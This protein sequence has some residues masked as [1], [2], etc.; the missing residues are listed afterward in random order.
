MMLEPANDTKCFSCL[1][2]FGEHFE[3]YD[4][5]RAGCTRRYEGQRSDGPCT[6]KGFQIPLRFRTSPARVPDPLGPSGDDQYAVLTISTKEA[7]ANGAAANSTPA[8]D[9]ATTG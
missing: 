8:P 6:C 1:H 2:P 3:T 9:A 5:Q 4:G 7:T